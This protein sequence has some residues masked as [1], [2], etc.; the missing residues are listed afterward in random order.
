MNSEEMMRAACIM[1]EAAE[2]NLRAANMVNDSVNQLQVL[3]G[4]GYGN[5]MDLL[6]EQLQKLSNVQKGDK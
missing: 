2:T 4:Q 1:R 3:I 5:N 6:I